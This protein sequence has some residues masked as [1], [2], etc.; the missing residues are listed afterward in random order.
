MAHLSA[1]PQLAY[2][3]HCSQAI[4]SGPEPYGTDR[5][6]NGLLLVIDIVKQKQ[7]VALGNGVEQEPGPLEQTHQ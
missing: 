5:H 7:I 6:F 3:V 4:L 2:M 1:G